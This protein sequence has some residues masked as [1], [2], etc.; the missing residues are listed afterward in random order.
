MKES[1]PSAELPS[2][3]GLEN[4]PTATLPKGKTTLKECPDYDTEQSDD[5][6]AVMLELWGMRSIPLL[7]SLPSQLWP[8]VVVPVRVLSMDQIELNWELM[9]N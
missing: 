2:R 4:T 9:Q 1:Y 6:A 7:P 3:L 5:E 8:G